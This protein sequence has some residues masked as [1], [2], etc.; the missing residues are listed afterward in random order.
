V[1]NK[2]SILKEEAKID[3][4]NQEAWN[5][6]VNDSTRAF[7]ISEQCV[8]S[9]RGINYT[10]GLA[11]GLRTLA[12]CHIRLSKYDEALPLLDEALS[13]FE[14]LNDVDGKVAIM[15]TSGLYGA[16]VA[17]LAAPWNSF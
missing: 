5:T 11:E 14:S 4:L 10:K 9:A 12:F 3:E 6:R 1:S 15:N 16:T 7:Q 2:T 13:L 8:A 17:I